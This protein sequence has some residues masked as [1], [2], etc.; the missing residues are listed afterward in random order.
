MVISS[1]IHLVHC[2]SDLSSS[3]NNLVHCL[4]A[5]VNFWGCQW[6]LSLPNW[7][8]TH[9]DPI[10]GC[11]QVEGIWGCAHTKSICRAY[12][13]VQNPAH[14]RLNFKLSLFARWADSN[15]HAITCCHLHHLVAPPCLCVC[16]WRHPFYHNN[17]PITQ[18][19]CLL[20]QSHPTNSSSPCVLRFADGVGCGTLLEDPAPGLWSATYH[21]V[22][23]C[24]W[25]KL[26]VQLVLFN[27][28]YSTTTMSM[29]FDL[30]STGIKV[31]LPIEM[32]NKGAV[33]LANSWSV[34]GCTSHVDVHII[35]PQNLQS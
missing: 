31:R 33:N 35:I 17:L 2:V 9:V 21:H 32:D 6:A 19:W 28:T 8:I 22:S 34:G 11:F 18:Q 3:Y 14:Q 26:N 7:L 4:L 13:W 24:V 20:Q 16:T 5:I 1:Y 27:K 30:M 23:L 25:W 10:L 15:I 29:S 12:G